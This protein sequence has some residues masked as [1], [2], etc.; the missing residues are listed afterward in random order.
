MAQAYVVDEAHAR[1]QLAQAVARR[2]LLK[3]GPAEVIQPISEISGCEGRGLGDRLSGEPH[4]ER[5]RFEARAAASRAGLG[6][7]VLP[8]EHADVLLV[9]LRFEPLEEREDAEVAPACVVRQK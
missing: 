7:L 4:R 2:A 3:H 9:A 1:T 8:Q 5:F 6:E